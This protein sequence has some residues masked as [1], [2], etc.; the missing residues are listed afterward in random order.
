MS[1]RNTVSEISQPAPVD[2]AFL[3][4][5][6]AGPTRR[7]VT[8][9]FAEETWNCS[10]TDRLRLAGREPKRP[11]SAREQAQDLSIAGIRDLG[12]V[13]KPHYAGPAHGGPRHLARE[14]LPGI[15]GEIYNRGDVSG[16]LPKPWPSS[17]E[18][19]RQLLSR[20][21]LGH[22]PDAAGRTETVATRFSPVTLAHDL[23]PC[24]LAGIPTLV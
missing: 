23:C 17:N 18:D 9:A 24:C 16:S 13:G 1:K 20:G 2:V 15:S 6:R 21:R 19:R 12:G 11:F 14:P 7:S 22:Q 5:I 3:K 10:K 8:E 4:V